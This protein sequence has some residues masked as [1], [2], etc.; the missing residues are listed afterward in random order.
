MPRGRIPQHL[1]NFLN[2]NLSAPERAFNVVAQLCPGESRLLAREHTVV[3][4]LLAMNLA[5]T[6]R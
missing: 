4:A 5:A 3:R 6:S 2:A 1:R